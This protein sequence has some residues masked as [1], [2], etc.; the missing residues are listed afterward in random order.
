MLMP[1]SFRKPAMRCSGIPGGSGAV[2]EY[3]RTD[4]PPSTIA[5]GIGLPVFFH[6]LQCAAP[7]WCMCQCIA[8]VFLSM[9][10]A[11]YMPMLRD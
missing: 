11:R 1:A 7:S 5:Q 6:A 9:S 10:C 3:G 8:V 4:S 2:A